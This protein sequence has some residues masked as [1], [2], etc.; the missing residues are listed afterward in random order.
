M[1]LRIPVVI[2]IC[3]QLMCGWLVVFSPL[4][5]NQ[6]IGPLRL[7]GSWTCDYSRFKISAPEEG[8]IGA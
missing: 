3:L 4:F 5:E 7:L 6:E 8:N 1:F 2:L